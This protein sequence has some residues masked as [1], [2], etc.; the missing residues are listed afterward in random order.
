MQQLFGFGDVGN[1]GCRAGDGM[2]QATL[3]ISTDVGFHPEIILI[4]LLR[5]VH[6]RVSGLFPV[7]GR[8]RGGEDRGVGNRA[9]FQEQALRCQLAVD[10]G[11]QLFRQAVCFQQ[12]TKLQ[13]GGGIRRILSGK[14]Y[15]DKAAECLTVGN[16]IFHALIGQ[17]V[18][19]LDEVDAEHSLQTDGRTASFPLGV[20]GLKHFQQGRPRDDP[21]HLS[22]KS[23][24]AG[25]ALLARVFHLRKTDLLHGEVLRKNDE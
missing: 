7:F 5:L 4:A 21:F 10:A 1:V 20:V 19:L 22:Q 9:F 25:D 23:L 16:G 2:Y 6:F 12:A 17:S 11:K 18:P 8:G 3:A 13:Q 14:V 24:T 15:P